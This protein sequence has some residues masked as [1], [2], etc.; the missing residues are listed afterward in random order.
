[1]EQVVQLGAREVVAPALEQ[2]KVDMVPEYEGSALNFLNDRDRVATADPVLTHARLEQAFAPRG[3][4]VLA[5][6]PAQDRNGFVVS[7]DLARRHGLAMDGSADDWW[8]SSASQFLYLSQAAAEWWLA[9]ER[10]TGSIVGYARSIERGGLLELTEFFVHP[11]QQAKGVGRALLGRAF[12]LGRGET[13]AIIATTDVP[14]L[15]R[16]YAADTAAR[17][18][19]LTLAG[20]P[21]DPRASDGLEIVRLDGAAPARLADVSAVERVVLGYPRGEAELR[22][23]LERR[24]GYLYRR[25]GRAVGF[26]FVG[27]E[28]AGPVAALTDEDLIA[29]LRHVES[30]AHALGVASLSLQVPGPNAVAVRHLVARGFKIDPWINLLMSNRPFGQFDRFIAFSPIFL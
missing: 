5:F 25:A 28:G 29:E 14:A 26:A 19:M 13:R 7:G 27:R 21:A 15:S 24:E 3:I 2:G 1:V 17:F 12:P 22:W 9:E 23:I 18:P 30:R 4:R 6:A 16:Y 20:A 11:G 10:A 8:Q